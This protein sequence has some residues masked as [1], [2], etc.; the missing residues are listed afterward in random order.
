VSRHFKLKTIIVNLAL[1][2][3][4]V[5]AMKP[6][7]A[8]QVSCDAVMAGAL[9]AGEHSPAFYKIQELADGGFNYWIRPGTQDISKPK[10]WADWWGSEAN[11]LELTDRDRFTLLE[12]LRSKDPS[13]SGVP[14]SVRV[15]LEPTH[16]NLWL[17]LFEY[18]TDREMSMTN[19]VTALSPLV[20]YLPPAGRDQIFKRIAE[21]YPT[22]E[23]E[24][25]NMAMSAPKRSLDLWLRILLPAD[26]IFMESFSESHDPLLAYQHYL[27]VLKKTIID[28]M[29]PNDKNYGHITATDIFFVADA[30]RKS[31]K[32]LDLTSAKI[33]FHGSFM[34]GLAKNGSD[35]DAL[36]DDLGSHAYGVAIR[37]YYRD[38]EMLDGRNP[39]SRMKSVVD[40]RRPELD[41]HFSPPH[42][43]KGQ[44]WKMAILEPFL[45]EVTAKSIYLLVIPS[46]DAAGNIRDDGNLTDCAT[47]RGCMKFKLH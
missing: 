19:L 22:A 27:D 40:E 1:V 36:E 26:E 37:Q 2:V 11:I 42:E 24:R 34:K 47:G 3:A 5:S 16:S 23:K 15:I 20:R 25:G 14:Y 13:L 4:M 33:Y 18:S 35:L 6:A 9:P 45:I 30:A 43:F 7:Q 38:R 41:L 28:R 39:V 21:K 8:S 29:P 17:Q 31:L 32:N 12:N 10:T 46:R 44:F